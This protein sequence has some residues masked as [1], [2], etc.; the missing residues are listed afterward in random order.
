MAYPKILDVVHEFTTRQQIK[1]SQRMAVE[2]HTKMQ[3][4]QCALAGTVEF[5]DERALDKIGQ[6]RNADD[7]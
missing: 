2:E 7:G 5:E 4:I 3:M 1:L 6:M